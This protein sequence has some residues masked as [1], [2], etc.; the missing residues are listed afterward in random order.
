MYDISTAGLPQDASKVAPPLNTPANSLTRQQQALGDSRGSG[1]WSN[2]DP[3]YVIKEC[4]AMPVK[5]HQK[6]SRY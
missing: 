5:S 6:Q 3:V 4:P 1:D 2:T